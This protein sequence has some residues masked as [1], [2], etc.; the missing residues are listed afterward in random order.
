MEESLETRGVARTWEQGGKT[1]TRQRV[2]LRELSLRQKM[3][4]GRSFVKTWERER[5]DEKGNLFRVAKQLVKRCCGS[6]LLKDSDGKNFS[7]G[8]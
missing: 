8:R 2:M 4:R 7:G 3:M 5:V 1:K 6:K